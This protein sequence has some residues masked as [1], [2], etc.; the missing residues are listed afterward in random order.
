MMN[1]FL[2]SFQPLPSLKFS[3]L[4]GLTVGGLSACGG[5]SDDSDEPKDCPNSMT[6]C[7]GECVDLDSSESHC[8]ECGMACDD[9]LVCSEG[10]C[11]SEEAGSGG[12]GEDGSGGGG[13]GSASGGRSS[14]SGGSRSVEKFVGNITTYD[15]VDPNGLTFS[16]YWDQITPE[17]AG[18]WGSVENFVGGGRNWGTLDA[19]YAYTESKGI[20]FKQHAFVWGSQQPNGNPGS[21]D[22]RSWI[23]DFCER[24]PNTKLIDVVNEPPPHTEP[25]YTAALGGGTNGDWA[26]ITQSFEWARE[27]C[28]G[29]IL[30][31]NDYN[32]IE[33]ENETDHFIDITKTVL[34][35]G[36]PI[37]AVGAQSHDLDHE[38][39]TADKVI[40]LLEKVHNQTGLPVYITEYDISDSNDQNQ[41]ALY[42]QHIPY[43]LETEWI[44]GVTIWGWIYGATWDRAPNSGLVN[45]GRSRP[46]MT[47]LMDL[48]DR[49]SP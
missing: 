36:G 23:Q 2:S 39:I 21:E 46:A 27:Y 5:G 28:P 3:L 47:Y 34:A 8:G 15:Q 29:A 18:K 24:Y 7:G 25:N 4:L 30:I 1:F 20:V 38:M 31:L 41:L 12:S 42:E 32:N 35:N 49:P 17:N 10:S 26:W 40:R 37:D 13:G 44:H 11:E 6:V 43:F 22:V 19:I 14:G 33:W 48:L 9:D 45:N 16:D